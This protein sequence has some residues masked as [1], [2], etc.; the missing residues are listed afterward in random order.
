MS[1]LNYHARVS[2][3]HLAKFA[4]FMAKYIGVQF[5]EELEDVLLAGLLQH[6]CSYP[7]IDL[8]I[9]WFS[10]KEFKNNN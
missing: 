7:S 4:L 8:S 2:I 5:P 10:E 6:A 9:V 3:H 1:K